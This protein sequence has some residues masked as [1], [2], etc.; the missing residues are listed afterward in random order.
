MEKHRG[1]HVRP[2]LGQ[3]T[4]IRKLPLATLMPTA[5][6]AFELHP[7]NALAASNYLYIYNLCHLSLTLFYYARF[8]A[9]C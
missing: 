9:V 8:I 3:T 2:T 6:L 7:H 4:V 1:R 5:M